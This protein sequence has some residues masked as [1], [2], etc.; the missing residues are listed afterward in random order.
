MMFLLMR[1]L[2]AFVEVNC[3]DRGCVFRKSLYYW[4]R[5]RVFSVG[6]NIADVVFVLSVFVD[7]AL[8]LSMR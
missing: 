1:R 8:I 3:T 2:L 6:I 4:Q 7:C 5:E